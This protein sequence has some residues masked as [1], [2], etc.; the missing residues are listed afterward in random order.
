ML[1]GLSQKLL[2]LPADLSPY[3]CLTADRDHVGHCA[4]GYPQA[5]GKVSPA[6]LVSN[7]EICGLGRRIMHLLRFVFFWTHLSRCGL[8]AYC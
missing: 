8:S 5:F 6:A 2:P 1:P 4:S 7:V 3:V